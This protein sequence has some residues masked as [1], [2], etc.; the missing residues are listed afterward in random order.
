MTIKIFGLKI[1]WS[2]KQIINTK[3]GN[4]SE[5]SKCKLNMYNLFPKNWY[6][7]FFLVLLHTPSNYTTRKSISLTPNGEYINSKVQPQIT[8]FLKD[9]NK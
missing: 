2:I 6:S 4:K 5:R 3:Q 7:N 1:L 9:K 8:H